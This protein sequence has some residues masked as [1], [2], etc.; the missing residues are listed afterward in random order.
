M[1]GN[2]AKRGQ[3]SKA[4]RATIASITMLVLS[5]SVMTGAFIYNDQQSQL[6]HAHETNAGELRV[7]S[8]QI[9]KNASE[10]A[11][12]KEEAFPLLKEAT[13]MFGQYI[14]ELNNA[15]LSVLPFVDTANSPASQ[16]IEALGSAWSEMKVE[17]DSILLS[18]GHR[19]V[20]S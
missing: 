16:Q 9:A 7:L 14:G 6:L 1:K 8:Q 20:T 2:Q 13:S 11:S 12:G 17:A 19:T 4:N 3:G 15:K 10:A 5:L 18:P